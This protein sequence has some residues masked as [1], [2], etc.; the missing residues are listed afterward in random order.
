M[1]MK[2]RLMRSS[3]G[4]TFWSLSTAQTCP[5][6][7]PA[8][9]LRF[10]PRSAVKQNWQSTAHPTWLEIQ[11]VDRPEFCPLDFGG[12]MGFWL[13][14]GSRLALGFWM[15]SGFSAALGFWA[16]SGFWLAQRFS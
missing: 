14:S 2:T 4:E 13:A 5:T 11:I 7:S 9:R 16:A 3:G 8:V 6:I 12:A 15:A 10:T 1:P